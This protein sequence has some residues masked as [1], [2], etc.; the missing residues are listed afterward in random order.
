MDA[1]VIVVGLGSMGSS[2]ARQLAARGL[3]VIGLDRFR[4]PHH[5]GAHAG[6]TRIIRMAYAEGA[7]YV[8]L[9]HTAYRAWAALEA[10][11]GQQLKVDTGGLLIGPPAAMQV[12]GA[13]E[14]ARTHGLAHEVLGPSEVATR[15]PQFRLE[16]HEVAVFEP[17]A[18]VLRPEATISAQ[19]ALAAAA[20]ADLR[21]DAPVTGWDAEDTGVTVRIGRDTL[22]AA[23]LVVAPGAWAVSALGELPVPFALHRRVQ[24]FW[25]PDDV[26][27]FAPGRMPVWIWEDET[28]QAGY[29]LPWQADA[30]G[31]K[32]AFHYADYPLDPDQPNPEATKVEVALMRDWLADRIPGLAAGRWVGGVTCRYMMTPDE[33]FV[34]G[35]H[36]RSPRVAIAAGFSGHGFKFV[37]LMGEILADLVLTGGTAHPIGLFDPQRVAVA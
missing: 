37:P 5:L 35:L 19:L 28:G 1:E 30:G 31:V 2:A 26:E 8:P 7:D 12:A 27:L 34:V 21:F 25:A 23:R 29:G 10:E 6:G 4:P 16:P 14:S 13:L 18:G 32:A 17:A 9:L 20:G 33:H 3:S 22:T 11:S 36:P 15:Y 24:H